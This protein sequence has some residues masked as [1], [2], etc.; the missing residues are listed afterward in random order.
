[1]NYISH[2]YIYEKQQQGL[3]HMYMY[4]Y[5]VLCTAKTNSPTCDSSNVSPVGVTH[6]PTSSAAYQLSVGQF[7]CLKGFNA[8][9]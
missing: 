6:P 9:T 5:A 7:T 8:Y 3:L 1:M 4:I 2:T